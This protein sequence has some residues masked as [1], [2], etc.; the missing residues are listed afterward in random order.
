MEIIMLGF[1]LEVLNKLYIK[2]TSTLLLKIMYDALI[3]NNFS[4]FYLS[5]NVWI[6]KINLKRW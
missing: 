4:G 5:A 1:C 6:F 2:G 3:Y